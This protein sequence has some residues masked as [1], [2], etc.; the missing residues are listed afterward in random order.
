MKIL[1]SVAILALASASLGFSDDTLS[2][3][4]GPG[5][6]VA[7]SG[8]SNGSSDS[9]FWDHTSWDG[10]NCNIGYFL[11]GTT[12]SGTG[13]GSSQGSP[14]YNP[15][16]S[17]NLPFLSS[18]SPDGSTT[19]PDFDFKPTAPNT[20]VDVAGFRGDNEIFGYYLESNSTPITLVP[21]FASG[22]P[23]STKSFDPGGAAFGFYLTDESSGL[24]YTTDANPGQFAVFDTNTA[25]SGAANGTGLTNFWI[26]VEDLQLPTGDMDYNDTIIHVTTSA[27]PEPGYIEVLALGLSGLWVAVRRR[28]RVQ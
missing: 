28:R 7:N 25:V 1:I 19:A 2:I 26:G 27:T 12:Q 9:Y 21:L 4:G 6:W 8:P 3:S 11:N 16:L 24:T 13:C 14:T 17:P 18:S 22:A 20:T 15:N 5:Y 23:T 10:G